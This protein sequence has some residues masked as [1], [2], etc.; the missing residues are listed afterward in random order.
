MTILSATP[1]RAL[2]LGGLAAPA[3]LSARAWGQRA[4]V[5]RFGSPMPVGST[6]DD[7]MHRFASEAARLSNNRLRVETFPNAQ[8]GGIKDM[9]TAVQLGTLSISAA[10]PAWYSGFVK[11]MDVFTLPYVTASPERLRTALEGPFGQHMGNLA[12]AAGFKLIG[13]WLMGPRHLVNNLRPLLSP[14]DCVG[15]KLRVISSQVY[16]SFIKALG[17]NPVVL[18]S[19]EIYLALQQHVVDGLEYPIPDLISI[20]LYEVDEIRF[21]SMPTRSISSSSRWARACGTG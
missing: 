1:R 2:L 16:I 12:E 9:L 7:A 14:A 19:P 21:D 3:I 5:L 13:T 17:A 10:V 15:L 18:D 20:K 8:L 11:P 6:Y 4:R